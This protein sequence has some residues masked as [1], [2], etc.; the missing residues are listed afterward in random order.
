MLCA[1]FGLFL[2]SVPSFAICVSSSSAVLRAEASVK[3]AVS[4]V[5][6]RYTPLVE[7]ERKG[8]WVKVSDQDG[9]HHWAQAKQLSKKIRCVS[10][11]TNKVSLRVGPGPQFPL[12][13]IPIADRYTPFKRLEE[14]NLDAE[15]WY[16]VVDI[17][18]V[19]HW[20]PENFLWRPTSV[21]SV[22]F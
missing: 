3:S 10:V 11:K 13:E 21:V 18:G 12:S 17:Y 6:P 14:I 16:P 8:I 2:I 22:G 7:I 15:S 1:T 9:K 5:V 20:I 19:K 4:W